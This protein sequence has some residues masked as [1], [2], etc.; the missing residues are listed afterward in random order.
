MV[1]STRSS[2][3][4]VCLTSTCPMTL[5]SSRVLK[6][7]WKCLLLVPQRSVGNTECTAPY[8]DY[9]KAKYALGW[10]VRSWCV[11]W[12]CRMKVI[13][14][15][16]DWPNWKRMRRTSWWRGTWWTASWTAILY[17]RSWI[18]GGS[19]TK[20]VMAWPHVSSVCS[21]PCWSI[22]SEA[23]WFGWFLS[24]TRPW[25]C[26]AHARCQVEELSPG[27]VQ[28]PEV[29]SR[30]SPANLQKSDRLRQVCCLGIIPRVQH[31]IWLHA[32]HSLCAF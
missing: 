15:P 5:D 26:R 21:M 14:D 17:L 11:Q 28:L 1:R 7:S 31:R 24:F 27:P 25:I 6:A 2:G 10:P 3:S 8:L 32:W 29:S 13:P 20:V 19:T 22:K 4:T 12:L 30:V 9:T 23:Q 18:Y 16:I